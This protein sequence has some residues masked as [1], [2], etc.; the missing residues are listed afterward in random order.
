M[1]DM[2][3]YN[4][5]KKNNLIKASA[6]PSLKTSE[7]FF[8]QLNINIAVEI[9]TFWGVTAAYIAQF[10]NKV[11][12][13]DII[14]HPQKYKVWNDFKVKN[15][16]SFHLVKSRDMIGDTFK[17]F[18]GIHRLTGKE[19]DIE[20]ILDKLTFDFA[21]VDGDHHYKNVKA[22][23]ELVKK[24][25]RV[26]FHDIIPEFQYINKFVKEIGIKQIFYN[27]GYWEVEK[28]KTKE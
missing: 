26:L 25:G 20:I 7:D 22:D 9:G 10:A 28:C 24:C 4:Y 17:D 3:I 12:T 11:H 14:D 15:K 18:Q 8:R 6:M 1:I 19:V 2:K 21:F 27:I 16:I 5:A 23:F 13:F